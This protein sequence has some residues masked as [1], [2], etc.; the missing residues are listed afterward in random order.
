MDDGG[1]IGEA[2]VAVG[3]RRHL[4]ERARRAEFLMMV[5][6]AGGMEV[7]LDPLLAGISQH[8]ADERR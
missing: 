4:L 5:G 6:K 2:E 7:E 1:R 8:L 3:Q